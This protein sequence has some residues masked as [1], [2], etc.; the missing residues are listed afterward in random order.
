ML[1]LIGFQELL[2]FGL[3]LVLVVG[4]IVAVANGRGDD[5]N[6]RLSITRPA[7]P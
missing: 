2:V 5:R 6:G 7:N 3:V 1:A 4:V